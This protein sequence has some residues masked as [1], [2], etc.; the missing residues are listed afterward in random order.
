MK[1]REIGLIVFIAVM[2]CSTLL[3]QENQPKKPGKITE[4]TVLQISSDAINRFYNDEK[5]KLLD[6]TKKIVE[7]AVKA[8]QEENK[9]SLEELEK[10][11]LEETDKNIE[12][13]GKA[14]SEEV[15]KTKLDEYTKQKKE[16]ERLRAINGPGF[17]FNEDTTIRFNFENLIRGE[18]YTNLTDGNSSNDDSEMRVLQRSIFG[19]NISYKNRLSAT[20]KLR[21]TKMWGAQNQNPFV[22][23]K[24]T[25]YNI[26]KD[27][28]FS[29]IYRGDYG[30]GTYEASIEIGNFRGIPLTL[31]AGF[32]QL[33][34]GDGRFIG[35]NRRWFLEAEPS[36]AAI[37]KY[38]FSKH[39]LHLIYSKIR[40]TEVINI[41]NKLYITP[42]DDLVGLYFIGHIT[43]DIAIDGYGFYNRIGVTSQSTSGEDI[44][45]GTI[46]IRSDSIIGALK[47]NGELIF[48]FGKNR[49]RDHIAGAA[50]L[51]LKYTLALNTSPYVWAGFSYATGDS[52]SKDTSLQFLQPYASN[53]CKYGVLNLVS[54]SNIIIPRVGAG[55]YPFPRFNVALNYYYYILASSKGIVYNGE[56]KMAYYDH[57]GENG[58]NFGWETDL[59]LKFKYNQYLTL[60]A[61][62]AISQPM[63][64]QINQTNYLYSD[65][66]GNPVSFGND[67]IHYGFGM[68]NLDF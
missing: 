17:V 45:I 32:M 28:V 54:L 12:S 36:A 43:D 27:T 33:N 64:Y 67:F 30:V 39:Q 18:A 25:G 13:K 1:T 31:S 50:D 55:F 53:E 20:Y 47:L 15:F 37:L 34:Y 22:T 2:I 44:N 26:P 19:G 23:Q 68:I 52:G 57:T 58:R 29:S 11:I 51:N 10:R 65:A 59:I 62:Y 56:N 24:T 5:P 42:G 61:G 8:A 46:G 21:Y 14:I 40:E 66:R 7:E 49:D 63:D 41:N 6:E 38:T 35:A 4:E 60:S 9:K 3:A 16:E 48:Q